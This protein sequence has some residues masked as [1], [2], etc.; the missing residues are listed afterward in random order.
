MYV[1]VENWRDSAQPNDRKA[2]TGQGGTAGASNGPAE[3]PA[4]REPGRTGEADDA[5]GSSGPVVWPEAAGPTGAWPAARA[6]GGGPEAGRPGPSGEPAAAPG[7]WFDK[8]AAVP[9]ASRTTGGGS[10]QDPGSTTGAVPGST[11]EPVS[12]GADLL[13]PFD[14]ARPTSRPSARS[15]VGAAG[16]P[17]RAGARPGPPASPEPETR[18][19]PEN[20]EVASSVPMTRVTSDMN[21][22]GSAEPRTE[23]SPESRTAPSTAPSTES[24]T[25]PGTAVL[26]KPVP[27]AAL[28]ASGVPRVPGA[29]AMTGGAPAPRPPGSTGPRP[30]WE[31]TGEP[32]RNHDPHEVTVQLDGIGRRLDGGRTSASGTAPGAA[33]PGGAAGLVAEG[34]KDSDGPVFVDESGRRSRRFRR[35]GIAVGLACGLYALVIVAT[36]L[37]GNSAAPWVP[38][39]IPGSDDGAPASKVEES[40]RPTES[41]APSADTGGVLP[42]VSAAPGG[43][44]GGTVP[45]AGASASPGATADSSKKPGTSGKKPE[46]SASTTKKSSGGTK[47]NPGTGGGD[48]G[49]VENP[50]AS[51]SADTSAGTSPDPSP[52]GGAGGGG[53]AGGTTNNAA[54]APAAHTPVAAGGSAATPAQSPE[55]TL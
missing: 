49:A 7:S 20:V 11:P 54:D 41:L 14:S 17:G 47:T 46:P 27:G 48:T 34:G 21:T 5:S 36:L 52:S 19:L 43:P 42:G 38:V 40:V 53:E 30:T 4:A 55:T 37:S 26:P 31:R 18:L 6:E 45:S 12:V 13:A 22:F 15:T 33:G 35:I 16:A 44:S 2:R 32:G 28:G 23:P 3:R 1:R 50:P 51:P 25:E 29:S 8:G 10:P 24:S 9:G 39:P